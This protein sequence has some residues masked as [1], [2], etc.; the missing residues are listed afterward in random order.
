MVRLGFQ[1]EDRRF[2]PHLT[3]GRSRNVPKGIAWTSVL[4]SVRDINVPGFEVAAISLMKSELRQTGA[5]Y[6]EIG[7]AELH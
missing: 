6:T 2:T 5:V 7:R 3:L 1:Q 4:E